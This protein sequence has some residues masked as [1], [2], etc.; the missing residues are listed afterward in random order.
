MG[1]LNFGLVLPARVFKHI[2]KKHRLA[3]NVLKT[4]AT[5]MLNFG[6]LDNVRLAAARMQI[7]VFLGFFIFDDTPS[8]ICTV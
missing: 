1:V 8:E 2:S 5:A 4:R 6:V 7:D 3:K